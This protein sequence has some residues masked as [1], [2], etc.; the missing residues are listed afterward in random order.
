[1]LATGSKMYPAAR[2][3]TRMTPWTLDPVSTKKGSS[4]R[5]LVVD[6]NPRVWRMYSVV[7]SG[8]LYFFPRELVSQELI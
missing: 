4:M 3:I 1:M 6:P 5:T 8:V 7:G 2:S